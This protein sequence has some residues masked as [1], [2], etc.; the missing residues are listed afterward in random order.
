MTNDTSE[1]A[2]IINPSRFY[3]FNTTTKG[4]HVN[5][6]L[7]YVSENSCYSN[8]VDGQGNIAYDPLLN[9][10]YS[11]SDYSPCIGKGGISFNVMGTTYELSLKDY[12]NN[13]RSI[14]LDNMPDLGAFENTLANPLPFPSVDSLHVIDNEFN[15]ELKWKYPYKLSTMIDNFE[16]QKWMPGADSAI[17]STTKEYQFSDSIIIP[18]Q[19]FKYVIKMLSKDKRDNLFSDTL[20]VVVK[21]LA[22]DS[23]QGFN[24]LNIGYNKNKVKLAEEYRA[25]FKTV[26][27]ISYIS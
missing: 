27:N 1:L 24:A 25:R 20:N 23:V 7:G 16:V 6:G 14:L 8:I 13:D 22:P 11:L 5:S 15:V 3:F 2:R 19:E 18:G 17:V 10:D 9:D 21:D 4:F 26:F 12:L